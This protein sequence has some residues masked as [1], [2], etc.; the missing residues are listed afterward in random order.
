MLEVVQLLQ[1]KMGRSDLAPRIL[2]SVK[3]EIHHQALSAEKARNVLGWKPSYNL[4]EGLQHT[5]SWYENYFALT[6]SLG[7]QA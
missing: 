3:A 6:S 5:I 7:A 4:E 2:N 1:L